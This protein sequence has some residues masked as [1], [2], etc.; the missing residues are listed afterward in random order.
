MGLAFSDCFFVFCY[1]PKFTSYTRRKIL[2]VFLFKFSPVF[3]S[4]RHKYF[5]KV[6]FYWWN[7]YISVKNKKN[8]QTSGTMQ[9]LQCAQC[10]HVVV[11]QTASHS[12]YFLADNHQTYSNLLSLPE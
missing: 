4:K 5:T 1:S 8:K 9:V 11:R 7:N 10:A 3:A 12:Y 6:F 2:A